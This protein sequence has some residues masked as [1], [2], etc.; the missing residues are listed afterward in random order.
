MGTGVGAGENVGTGVGKGVG[1]NVGT[2]VGGG[3]GAKVGVGT[4]V[5]A[6]VGS[7]R[8]SNSQS[9][10]Q[11][12]GDASQKRLNVITSTASP[13]ALK[14]QRARPPTRKPLS[15]KA[16][17]IINESASVSTLDLP[18]LY[19]NFTLQQRK[20]SITANAIRLL[21]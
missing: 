5:G 7:S 18:G 10:E 17:P 3:A 11:T 16:V 15:I 20:L 9:S 4:R 14:P 21:T 19:A 6:G 2:G 13:K 12:E 8:P 1:E